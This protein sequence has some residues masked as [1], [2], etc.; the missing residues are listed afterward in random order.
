MLTHNST[1]IKEAARNIGFADCRIAKAEAIPEETQYLKRWLQNGM[2]GTMEYMARNTDKRENPALLVDGCQT[3]VSLAVNYYPAFRQ[4]AD[5]PQIA[6]YAYGKDYHWVV[7]PMLHRLMGSIREHY[8]AVHGR[9]FTDSAPVMEHAWATRSGL[10]WTGKHSLVIHPQYGSY[11]FLGELFLDIAVEPDAPIANRCGACTR[12]MDACPVQAIVAPHV[13]DAR[14]CLSYLT[15]EHKTDFHP[16]LSLHR[17]LFGCD[18]CQNACPC[19]KKAQPTAISDF[20]PN[21]EML[22]MNETEWKNLSKEDFERMTKDSPL[23]R[24]GFESLHRNL[25]NLG[26]KI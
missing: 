9:V 11:I 3:V 17:H 1:F 15:I 16:P 14:R 8:G 24:A 20:K 18:L 19:N 21:R 12:C 13:V 22:N 23:Q 10:G 4:R 2:Y 5:V 26:N 7:K 25:K 6:K